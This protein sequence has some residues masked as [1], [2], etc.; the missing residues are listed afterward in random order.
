[1]AET[2]FHQLTT[3]DNYLTRR[4][5]VDVVAVAAFADE[6]R[7]KLQCNSIG[8]ILKYS[9]PINYIKWAL[10]A[11]EAFNVAFFSLNISTNIIIWLLIYFGRVNIS[12]LFRLITLRIYHTFG[13]LYVILY[14]SVKPINSSIIIISRGMASAV[15]NRIGMWKQR[16]VEYK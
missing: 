7:H 11:G 15:Q 3:P 10:G 13:I 14:F 6:P 8:R 1:M 2:T 4:A 12:V 9:Q 16:N 5:A